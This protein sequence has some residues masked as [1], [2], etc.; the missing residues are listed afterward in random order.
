MYFR[1]ILRAQRISKRAAE[2]GAALLPP[3]PS[4]THTRGRSHY[5]SSPGQDGCAHAGATAAPTRI[6]WKCFLARG[7]IRPSARSGAPADR[8]SRHTGV[9]R[10]K[11]G[12]A[13]IAVVSPSPAG[14][15]RLALREVA[16]AAASH[17]RENKGSPSGDPAPTSDRGTLSL[18]LSL[19]G[20]PSRAGSPARLAVVP[21]SRLSIYLARRKRGDAYN[22]RVKRGNAG[23][24]TRYTF[25]RGD[26][27]KLRSEGWTCCS[28]ARGRAREVS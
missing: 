7:A 20:S 4:P 27:P 21:L 11:R 16:R 23:S 6:A 12:G 22:G 24:S 3:P 28:R 25:R 18:S 5:S 14:Q 2:V 19:I 9:V 15:L 10:A 1:L 13:R 8:K 17:Q 26:F